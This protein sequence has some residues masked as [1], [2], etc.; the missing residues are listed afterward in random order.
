MRSGTVCRGLGGVYEVETPEGVVEAVLRG[1]IK[2]EERTGEKVVVGD[3]VDVDE[4]RAGEGTVWSIVKV[5][6]RT[7]VLARKAPGKAPR[8]KA[9]V[10]NVDQVL[11]VFAA[12]N[13]DPHLRMLDRFLVIAASSDIAPVIV[14]NKTDVAGMDAARALFAP[15]ERAGYTV[16]YTAA[17]DG[18][19]VDGLREALCGRLSALA[20]PSGVGKSSLL[21]AV[22][23]GLGLRVSEVS[24]AVNKGRH[25]TVT[26]QLIPLECGGWVAD[27]PGLREVG[28]WEIEPDQ[29]QFYFPEFEP[30]LG[31][32]RYP[33]CTHTHEPG[34]AVRA[35]AQS[36]EIDAGRYDSYQRMFLGEDEE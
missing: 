21:N 25:T 8:P 17:R 3:R 9:I 33:T 32:C 14:V 30:L 34:C 27:T 7:T 35:A 15:Y 2:R 24:Q 26:A 20:G 1:R 19:G 28:L 11:V 12:A 6:E 22:Q 31:D 16:H 5:H 10:A 18:T 13:P 23:P 36:G 29:L 4:D